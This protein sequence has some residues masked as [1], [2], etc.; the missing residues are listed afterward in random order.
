MR[1]YKFLSLKYAR[2]NLL[3]H[4]IKISKYDEMNDPYELLGIQLRDPDFKSSF[5][6]VSKNTGVLCFSETDSEVLLWSHYAANHRGCCI[7]FD[8]SE[9]DGLHPTKQVKRPEEIF[10]DTSPSAEMERLLIES[11]DIPITESHP[12]IEELSK[13]YLPLTMAILFSKYEGWNYEKERRLMLGLTPLQ[14]DGDHY[15]ADFGEDLKP[16]EVLLGAMCTQD[17]EEK[18]RPAV[19]KYDPP[20]PIIRTALAK[21]EFKIVRI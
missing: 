13:K 19:N 11:G 21:D 7:G 20:L 4:R 9:S 5:M 1:L 18:L 6:K 8:V 2:E 3:K 15:F 10:T 12:E 17:D 14:K 16:I